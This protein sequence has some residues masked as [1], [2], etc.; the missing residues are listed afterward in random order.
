MRG[1]QNDDEFEAYLRRRSMLSG[2]KLESLEPPAALDD[3]VLARARRAIETPSPVPRYQAP[4]WA[5]PVGLAATIL[6]CMSVLLNISLN[7]R[8]HSAELTHAAKVVA[9]APADASPTA[10][11][12]ASPAADAV[13][14]PPA[15]RVPAANAARSAAAAQYAPAPPAAA[16]EPAPGSGMAR[17][18]QAADPRAWL[19][20]IE[21]LRAQGKAEQAEAEWKRFRQAFPAYPV[22]SPPADS[23]PPK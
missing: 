9:Q 5:F 21:S 8:R 12:P 10:G 20:R 6:L 2:R 19:K 15:A 23:G 3:I 16:A 14:A 22:T 18:R 13:S 11:A 1:P 7:M 4:R 17:G